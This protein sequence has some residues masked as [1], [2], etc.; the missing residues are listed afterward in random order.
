V[1]ITAFFTGASPTTTPYNDT[2]GTDSG[3]RQE[4]EA[5]EDGFD[6]EN[7][8]YGFVGRDSRMS[9]DITVTFLGTSSGGG[10]TKTRNCSSLVV[11]ML[12]DGTLW[13]VYYPS[14]HI[15]TDRPCFAHS[16]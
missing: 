16:I 5:S 14:I 11:D 2:D 9:R 12:G 10:P 13:S 1:R 15:P 8:D 7:A 6:Y 4:P 3:L